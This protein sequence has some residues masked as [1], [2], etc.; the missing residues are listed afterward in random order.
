LKANFV[1]SDLNPCGGG[2]RLT[3]LTMQA[4]LDMGVDIDLTTLDTPDIT[5]LEN[6]MESILLLPSEE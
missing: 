5:K 3:L 4:V 6:A 1:Y 2:E